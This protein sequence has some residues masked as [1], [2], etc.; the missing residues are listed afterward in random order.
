MHIYYTVKYSV[1]NRNEGSSSE[2]SF[3]MSGEILVISQCPES[4]Y[5]VL[6]IIAQIADAGSFHV[7]GCIGWSCVCV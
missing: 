3:K 5:R 1:G 2:T 4:G 7:S 6:V